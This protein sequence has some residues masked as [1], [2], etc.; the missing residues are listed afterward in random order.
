[1]LTVSTNHMSGRQSREAAFHRKAASGFVT[2]Q[3]ILSSRPM[4]GS[5][6]ER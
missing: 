6:Q 3:V 5:S 2:A 1:V 4:H